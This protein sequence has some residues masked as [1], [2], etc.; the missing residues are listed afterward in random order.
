M[1]SL[2]V[3]AL[4]AAAGGMMTA[5][6]VGDWYLTLIK[7]PLNPPGFVFGPVWTLLYAMMAIAAWRVY[8]SSASSDAKSEALTAYGMQL[9]LNLSWSYFFFYQQNPFA[10]LLVIITMWGLIAATMILFKR[11]DRLSGQLLIPYLTWVS[12]AAYLNASIWWLNG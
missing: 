4:I 3:V 5:A 7:P 6:S 11:I 12:F 8:I 2:I 10:A 9:A 1:V